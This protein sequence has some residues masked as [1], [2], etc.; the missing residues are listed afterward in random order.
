MVILL[1]VVEVGS[2]VVDASRQD[3]NLDRS[4]PDVSVVEL[5]LLNNF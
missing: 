4:A 1:V 2:E 3:R 5:M